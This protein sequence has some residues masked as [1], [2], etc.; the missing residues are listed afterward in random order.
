MSRESSMNYKKHQIDI[1]LNDFLEKFNIASKQ[2]SDIINS[3]VSPVSKIATLLILLKGI[4]N[5]LDV[6]TLVNLCSNYEFNYG[7]IY[8]SKGYREENKNETNM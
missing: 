1:Q 4:D 3:N 8:D 2:I 6:A 5:S 7:C